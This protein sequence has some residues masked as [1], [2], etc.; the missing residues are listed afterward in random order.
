MTRIALL[1]SHYSADHLA[2]VTSEMVRLGAPKIKAVWLE[3]HVM[4]AALEG[5]HRL[6]AAHALGLDPVIEEVE[7]SDSAINEDGLTV[8]AVC[9]DAWQAETLDWPDALEVR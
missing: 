1:H 9:D 3:C 4:W 2:A 5:C 6:R 7:Y 8:S